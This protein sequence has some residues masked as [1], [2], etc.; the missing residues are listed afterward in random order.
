LLTDHAYERI[1]VRGIKIEA[2]LR[3][4]AR[5]NE[6]FIDKTQPTMMKG[7]TRYALV[8]HMER[9]KYLV[10]VIEEDHNI[11]VVT[12]FSI[13]GKKRYENHRKNKIRKKEWIPL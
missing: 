7:F 3:V 2:I 6:K 11:I 1:K 13:H 4:I 8:K 5:P 12:G 10:V 9:E